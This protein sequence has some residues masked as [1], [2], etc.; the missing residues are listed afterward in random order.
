MPQPGTKK[1]V[2]Q[3]RTEVYVPKDE[4]R[5][6]ELLSRGCAL[7]S[8]LAQ[9]HEELQAVKKEVGEIADGRRNGQGTVHLEAPTGHSATVVWRKRVDISPAKAAEL[10]KTLGPNFHTLFSERT[11]FSLAKGYERFMSLPQGQALDRLKGDIAAA[12]TVRETGPA[13]TFAVNE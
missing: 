10:K 1:V 6:T 13:C 8:A 4:A 9:L 7:A 2:L 12:I 5:L 3:D 11:A